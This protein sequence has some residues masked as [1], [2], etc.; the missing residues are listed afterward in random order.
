MRPLGD[1]VFVAPDHVPTQTASGLAI[2]ED[3][4]QET[5]GVVVSVGGKVIDVKAGQRVVFAPNCG[6][7]MQIEQQRL[8]VL[9]ERDVI[10]TLEGNA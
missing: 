8:F 9:R 6:Q 3:W 1:R 5:S 7:E 2:V 4:P 10:A